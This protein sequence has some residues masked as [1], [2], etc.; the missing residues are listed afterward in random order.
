MRVHQNQRFHAMGERETKS[1]KSITGIR[2]IIVTWEEQLVLR[3]I[4]GNTFT[5]LRCIPTARNFV[6]CFRITHVDPN[7]NYASVLA[8]CVDTCLNME[9][10]GRFLH[11]AGV[12]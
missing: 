11:R 10:Y 1:I 6:V 8:T 12:V 4:Q 5:D 2:L 3:C 9:Q 7:S